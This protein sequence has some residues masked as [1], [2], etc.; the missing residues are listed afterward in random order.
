MKT[1][2]KMSPR[3]GEVLARKVCLHWRHAS[4]LWLIQIIALQDCSSGF[5][6]PR[7]QFK[8]NLSLCQTVE[9][10]P[11]RR[12]ER[13]IIHLPKDP[14]NIK[15]DLKM[16]E[17]QSG[18]GFPRNIFR[19]VRRPSQVQLDDPQSINLKRSI[20]KRPARFQRY[21]GGDLKQNEEMKMDQILS[22]PNNPEKQR[23]SVNPLFWRRINRNIKR[24][25]N[26][27]TTSE[28]F[29]VEQTKTA[30]PTTNTSF[31]GKPDLASDSRIRISAE[32]QESRFITLYNNPSSSH[33]LFH[34]YMSRPISSFSIRSFHDDDTASSS[35]N[36]LQSRNRRTYQH[37]RWLVRKLSIE[38]AM[39][40]DL[41]KVKDRLEEER[42][43]RLAVPLMPLLGI[44]LTPV[45]DFEVLSVQT[46]KIPWTTEPNTNKMLKIRSM[47][48]SLLSREDEVRKAMESRKEKIHS[49]RPT[50][51]SQ[52]Q[53]IREIGNNAIDMVSKVEDIIKP[54]LSFDATITWTDK[55]QG[56]SNQTQLISIKASTSASFTWN[57]KTVHP[58]VLEKISGIILKRALKVG[59]IQLLTQIERDFKQ[60]ARLS[61]T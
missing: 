21:R 6:L 37:R 18:N 38:E 36:P 3:V 29:I 49:P 9:G 32:H 11:M 12:I 51:A 8:R 61:D 45:V 19:R 46:S 10:G 5:N 25:G 59:L 20:P 23:Q 52:N 28:E 22:P 15:N 1:D 44:N 53:N 57:Q 4:A 2:N 17:S 33:N 41:F 35:M 14:K 34:Q 16:D 50:K 54:Y 39:Q 40:D 7:R 60:W 48:L 13:W 58:F 56:Q 43:F 24:Q 27:L 26:I 42:Y 31:Q 47:R 30:L 55:G